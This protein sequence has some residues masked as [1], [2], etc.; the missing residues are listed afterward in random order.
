MGRTALAVTALTQNAGIN[1]PTG[2]PIDQTNG[3]AIALPGAGPAAGTADHL[4]LLIQSTSLSDQVVTV[5]GNSS[6]T[7]PTRGGTAGADLTVTC[8]AAS[9]GCVIGP[10]EVTRFA[11]TGGA[12]WVDFD[13]GSQ[14]TI[15]AFMWPT[16]W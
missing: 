1:I 7:T 12:V 11:Q 4:F 5:K 10:L 2:T 6:T 3:F 14:G 16:R 15:T 8:H 13:A 9:G